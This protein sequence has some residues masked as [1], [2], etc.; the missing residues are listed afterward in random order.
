MSRDLF[1][2]QLAVKLK[3]TE[4]AIDL[5]L[6]EASEQIALMVRGR[7]DHGFAASMGHDA[8]QSLAVT[9]ASLFA[10]RDAV[11]IAHG[12]LKARADELGI[13]YVAA[14]GPETKPDDG[15]RTQPIGRLARVA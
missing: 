5:A 2:R 11:V 12:Q 7:L 10:S 8:L 6:A 13:D 14:S 15:P 1:G 4:K 9:Q 3:K